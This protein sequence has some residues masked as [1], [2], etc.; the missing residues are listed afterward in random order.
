MFVSAIIIDDQM[1][2][3]FRRELAIQPPQEAQEFLMAVTRHTFSHHRSLQNIQSCEQGGG[4]VALIVVSWF[5]IAPSSWADP[6]GYGLRLESD[7]SHPHTAPT[8][9]RE[10]SDTGPPHP[11]TS[12][13]SVCPGRA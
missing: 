6:A 7:S 13:R 8:P 4:A 2:I 11:S 9:G 12:P 5:R 1:E 3:Q 10:D